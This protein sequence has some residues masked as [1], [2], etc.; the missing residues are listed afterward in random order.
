MGGV[1]ASRPAQ[2]VIGLLEINLAAQPLVPGG[3]FRD[4][5]TTSGPV[6]ATAGTGPSKMLLLLRADPRTVPVQL[7]GGG[8]WTRCGHRPRG[9][10]GR[11]RS[12]R[13]RGEDVSERSPLKQ[14]C[15][16]GRHGVQDQPRPSLTSRSEQEG[17]DC[18][19]EEGDRGHVD[20]DAPR[21]LSQ[22]RAPAL[23]QS[24]GV[25]GVEVTGPYP[26]DGS[27]GANLGSGAA[28]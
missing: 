12:L 19:V 26:R 27:T 3:Q 14:A 5:P 25:A 23:L 11:G 1:S 6:P 8:L 18:A 2:E 9:G 4:R 22:D 24:R 21:V 28:H 13:R 16:D 20:G 7:H 15:G 10:R 17:D